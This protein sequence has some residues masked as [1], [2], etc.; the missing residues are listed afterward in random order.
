MFTKPELT[1]LVE[2]VKY[3]DLVGTLKSAGPFTVFAPT[4]Q[5]FR[6]LGVALNTPLTQPSDIR[7]LPKA[8][9]RAVLLTHALGGALGGRFTSELPAGTSVTSAGGDPVTL[10]AFTNGVF[11]VQAKG[12]AAPANMVIPDVQC[13]NGVVHVIDRVL[14]P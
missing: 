2:A 11:T 12:N 1:F 9:V 7:K 8:T 3:A 4:D 13:T 14:L 10:G 6:D 5:A